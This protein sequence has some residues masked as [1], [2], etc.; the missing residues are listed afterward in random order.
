MNKRYNTVFFVIVLIITTSNFISTSKNIYHHEV[1]S[2]STS[3][4]IMPFIVGVPRSLYDLDPQFAWDYDSTNVIDQVCEGL[5]A[6]DL[7]DPDLRI[8]PRLASSLGTWNVNGDELTIPLRT[9]VTFHDGTP[10]DADAVLFTWNRMNWALSQVTQIA[11]LYEFPNGTSIVKQVI[12]NNQYSVTFKLQA[13]YVPFEALLCFSGSYILS[14][15]STPATAWIDTATG[16]LVGTGPFVYDNNTVNEVNFHAYNNYWRG[17]ASIE[18]MSFS[19][20]TDPIARNNALLAG[21]VDFLEGPSSDMIDTFKADPDI[22]MLDA[23]KKSA[24]IYYLGMNNVKID[25]NLREAISYAIDYDYIINDIY[26]GNAARS[27]SPI[28]EGIRYSNTTFSE[29]TFNIPFARSLMQGMG[30]GLGWDTSYPGISEAQWSAAS[31]ATINYTYNN[32]NTIRE[33]LLVLL[34][35]NLDKIGI[36]VLDDGMT[37]GEFIYRLYEIPPFTRNMLDLFWIGSRADYNDPSYY[38]NNLL[39]NRSVAYNTAQ[40]DGWLAA[41]E[42]GRNPLD[43]NDNVQ[44]LMEAAQTQAN[45]V[46][47]KQM[48]DRIQELLITRDMPWA[49]GIVPKLFHAHSN[50]LTG[51][52]QN[53]LYKLDF[54][55]CTWDP[56]RDYTIQI[57]DPADITYVQGDLGHTIEWYITT[58]DL[59]NPTYSIYRNTTLLSSGTWSSGI[60]VTVNVDALAA[61]TYAFRIEVNNKNEIAE[62][63]VIVT[64]TVPTTAGSEE[65]IFGYPTII[66]IGISMVCLLF[67]YQRLRKK[68]KLS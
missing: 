19:T 14:P 32:G 64:V 51:F 8:I 6:Y 39:T 67:I 41:I 1:S 11:S 28:P 47:R 65:Q 18:E 10:F 57:L 68:L 35:D 58:A 59:L 12:K 56:Y 20:I 23:G 43:M 50:N 45:P 46:L 22:T 3:Q 26:E 9:G 42:D 44:L 66:F 16:D 48:Y 54:F 15:T 60:P 55:S 62:D 5:Y 7:G 13:P 61:G 21:T 49:L 34:N 37:F 25:R 33:D 31:F 40:Y 36:T 2:L 63:I 38:T 53:A 24:T 17:K 30:Y 4:G 29:P 52:Q 27:K